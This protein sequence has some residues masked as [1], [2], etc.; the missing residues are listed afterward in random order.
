MAGYLV[1]ACGAVLMTA[2]AAFDA[3]VLVLL[4]ALLLGSGTATNLQS[5]YAAVDLAD[6][7]HRA[8]ALS[9]VVWA[10]TVGVVLGPNLIGPGATVARALDMP[11]LAGPLLFSLVAFAVASA[12]LWLMLRP[13]P[14]LWRGRSPVTRGRRGTRTGRCR[15]RCG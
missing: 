7:G 6:A 14:L 2:G 11:E 4:G 13:D 9:V 15:R 10:T 5:R 3:F 12:L 1:A 8:R